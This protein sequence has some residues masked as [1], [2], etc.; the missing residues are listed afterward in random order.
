MPVSNNPF[1][2]QIKN[3]NFL[4]PAGFKFSL[5]KSSEGVNTASSKSDINLDETIKDFREF[6]PTVS[7]TTWEKSYKPVLTKTKELLTSKK[8]PIDGEDLMLKA[9]KQWEQ[10]SRSRQI[11]RRA[12]QKI[13]D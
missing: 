13:K 8:K 5:A 3:R 4:S 11:A 2:R 12:I 9:L 10:G 1:V 7:K 6:L